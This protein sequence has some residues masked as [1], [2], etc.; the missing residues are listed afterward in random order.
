MAHAARV[1]NSLLIPLGRSSLLL[2]QAS[3]AEV[4]APQ[5]V[6]RL[7]AAAPWLEGVFEWRHEQVPLISLDRMCGNAPAEGQRPS[8]YVVL[9]GVEGY[10]GL[11]FYAVESFGLPRSMKLVPESLLKRDGGDFECD[12]VAEHVL[13]DD[14]TAFIPDTGVIERAIRAQLQRL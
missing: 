9:Y 11:A 14:Q 5:P 3:I 12:I 2:P 6:R 7:E 10:P 1:I 13:A 8:R 4:V